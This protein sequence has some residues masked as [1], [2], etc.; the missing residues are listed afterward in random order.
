[1]WVLKN[2][3]I[4]NTGAKISVVEIFRVG[5]EQILCGNRSTEFNHLKTKGRIEMCTGSWWV[6]LRE[7]GHWGDQDVDGRII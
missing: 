6:S 7:R 2:A 3:R 4:P 5:Y 1:M